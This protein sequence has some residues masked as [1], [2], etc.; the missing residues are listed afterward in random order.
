MKWKL[1]PSVH[2]YVNRHGKAV[3]YLR[4]LGQP[5]IRL[6]GFP[7]SPEFLAGYET[8]RAGEQVTPSIGA[9]RTLLGTVNAA[10]VSYYLST[11]FT[12]LAKSTQGNRR[13]MLENFRV[14]H[15]D[16][17]IA[18]MHT[19]A[20]QIILSHKTPAAQRN[21]VKAMRGL[22]DHCMSVGMI[23]D[24]PLAGAKLAKMKKSS[25]FHAWS[26]EEISQYRTRHAPGTK[27][28]LALELLLNTGHAR[29]DVV[30][31]GWQHLNLKSW[32]LSMR[33]QKTGVQFDIPMLPDLIA[34]LE[35]HPKG[36]QLAFLQTEHGKPHTA[37]GFGNKFKDW[38]CQANLPHCSAHG[39]RKASAIRHALKG[40]SAFELM[41][42]HGWTTIDEAQRY[43]E[44]ANRIKLAESA[45]AKVIRGTGI[46]SPLN[47][48]SQKKA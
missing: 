30:R 43:V 15:G 14:D 6:R 44:D 10:L 5:K 33:R 18:L 4:R 38:C 37:A 34:E 36:E 23:E 22:V 31:M 11:A 42:W 7:G 12:S 41:A 26:E 16:K 9:G 45:G 2:G 17:Q 25:G 46:G 40:A 39:L 28:R 48:V 29:A 47:P 3:F 32:K 19:K 20:L 27:A 24:D 8:A 21:F 1:P 35:L 13:A